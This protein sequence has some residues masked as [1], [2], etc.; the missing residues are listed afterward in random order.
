MEGERKAPRIAHM[1]AQL[2]RPGCKN[3]I[4]FLQSFYVTSLGSVWIISLSRLS[5]HPKSRLAQSLATASKTLS[6]P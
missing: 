4:K 2:P 5:G 6:R 3:F 1:V